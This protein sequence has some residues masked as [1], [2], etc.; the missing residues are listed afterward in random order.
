MHQTDHRAT[1]YIEY[2]KQWPELIRII[3]EDLT[4]NANWAEGKQ[5]IMDL[6]EKGTY[7]TCQVKNVWHLTRECEIFVD[8]ILSCD[9]TPTK[10]LAL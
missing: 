1:D 2:I 5:F 7:D 10:I 9:D 4:S 6:A 3:A 8:Q